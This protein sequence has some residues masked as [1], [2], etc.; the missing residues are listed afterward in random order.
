MSRQ[1]TELAIF[2]TPYAVYTDEQA[3][4]LLQRERERLQNMKPGID[5]ML[6]PPPAPPPPRK[7]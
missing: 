5:S 4:S 1:R 2:L 7:P 6:P 3:D